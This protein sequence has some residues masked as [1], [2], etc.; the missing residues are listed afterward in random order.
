[1]YYIEHA[2]KR[3]ET[4]KGK[5]KIELRL[6]LMGKCVGYNVICLPHKQEK[7]LYLH[8]YPFPSPRFPLPGIFLYF[9]SFLSPAVPF[10]FFFFFV[11][12]T[13]KTVVVVMA[14]RGDQPH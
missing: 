13:P 9:P 7:Y 12:D 11:T 6:S 4:K 3:K 10:F 14:E 8:R 5:K 1:M 2:M